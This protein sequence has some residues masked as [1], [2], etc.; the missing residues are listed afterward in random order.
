[1]A[2]R[3]NEAGYSEHFELHE[4][5]GLANDAS[6]QSFHVEQSWSLKLYLVIA[7]RESDSTSAVKVFKPFLPNQLHADSASLSAISGSRTF[8]SAE[9]IH[10]VILPRPRGVMSG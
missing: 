4:K 5:I 7:T 6:I 9:T 3:R 1:L 2:V 10:M 8:G